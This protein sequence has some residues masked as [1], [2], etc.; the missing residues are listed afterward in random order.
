AGSWGDVGEIVDEGDLLPGRG[1]AA[2]R[3]ASAEARLFEDTLRRPVLGQSASR[4]PDEAAAPGEL[5]AETER[6][7]GHAL[8]AVIRVHPE[9][10]LDGVLFRTEE[11]EA[12]GEG[13][14]GGVG[15]GENREV[16][17]FQAVPDRPLDQCGHGR[18]GVL[19]LG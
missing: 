18:L 8:A 17:A 12:P 19:R 2:G 16:T 1:E 4:E 3:F 9:A 11:H 6:G 14:R 7:P 13:V 5:D 10:D 15:D